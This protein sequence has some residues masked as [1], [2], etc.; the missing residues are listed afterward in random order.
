VAQWA[1]VHSK[2]VYR[3]IKEGKLEAIQRLAEG[4]LPPLDFSPEPIYPLLPAQWHATAAMA[5]SI[6]KNGVGNLQGEMGFGKSITAAPVID[7]L[8]AYPALIICPPHLVPKWIREI[9]ETLPTLS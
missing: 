3:W 2:K 9:E 4:D 1:R 7:L 8:N 5:R 6:R